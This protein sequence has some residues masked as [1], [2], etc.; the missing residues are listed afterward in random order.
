MRFKATMSFGNWEVTGEAEDPS[1]LG[2]EFI[3]LVFIAFK[4]KLFPHSKEV[5]IRIVQREEREC[6]ERI[7]GNTQEE[8]VIT[9]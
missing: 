6:F 2:K 8:G 9:S 7:A 4:K 1:D 3:D 5:T